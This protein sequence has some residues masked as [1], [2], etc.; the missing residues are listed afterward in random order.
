MKNL[1]L[2]TIYGDYQIKEPLIELIKTPTIQ[3]LKKI[4]QRGA[5]EYCSPYEKFIS[6]YDHSIGVLV[7]LIRYNANIKTQIAGLL[8]DASHTV[9]S[10]VG[11]FLFKN[12][13]HK[14][15]YQD[16]IHE[17]FL[18][19]Q[20]IDTIL[21]KYGF[22]LE[23]ILHKSGHHKILEQDLPDI[24]I[25]RLEY[26]LQI[27][28][29]EKI[30]NKKNISEILNNLTFKNGKWFFTEINIAKKFSEISLI[31]TEKEWGSAPNIFSY[32]KLAKA[33]KKGLELKIITEHEIHFSTDDIIWNKLENSKNKEI[34]KYL[35]QVKN[36]QKYI[37][38]SDKENHDKILYGKFRGIN[39]LIKTEKGLSRLTDLN[40]NFS[41]E[42]NK[43]KKIIH[44]GWYIKYI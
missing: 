41:K 3:R 14:A 19:K 34:L 42:Y 38:I 25:D 23:E 24:C 44:N 13:D 32:A 5:T 26:N 16:K 37:K 1:T 9:F 2:K 21:Q 27:G 43:V 11:D 12:K 39:P 15:S 30:I 4:S 6:R 17:W 35:D 33:L 10:H 8:H 22:S 18:K 28:L 20:K 31:M 29:I 40:Q 7:L 36:P